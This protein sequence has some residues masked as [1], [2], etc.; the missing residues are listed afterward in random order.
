M[1]GFHVFSAGDEWYG[2]SLDD[3]KV[4][5]LSEEEAEK[6]GKGII[7]PRNEKCEEQ[8]LE[9]LILIAATDCNMRCRYC[10]ADHGSYGYPPQLMPISTAERAVEVMERLTTTMNSVS[11]FGGE[12][13]LN[14][15]LIEKIVPYIRTRHEDA[16]IRINTNGTL[17]SEKVIDMIKRY[18]M[19]VV[20]SLDGPK[21]I[22]DQLRFFA[23][24]RGSY[25][26]VIKNIEKLKRE[27]IP[28]EIEATYTK[29][30]F[31]AGISAREVAEH[32]SIY[33]D[34]L[35]IVPV[36]T[37]DTGLKLSSEEKVELYRE[38]LDFL[39]EERQKNKK[40]FINLTPSGIGGRMCDYICKDA[41]GKRLTVYPTGDSYPCFHAKKEIFFLGNI[42]DVNYEEKYPA[43]M[44]RAKK[45][46][47]KERLPSYWFVPI[48]QTCLANIAD[49]EKEPHLSKEDIELIT[50]QYEYFIERMAN[51]QLE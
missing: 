11:F 8:T 44:E 7:E 31:K 25:D 45:Y 46:M 6:Y 13:L 27:G 19:N 20:L 42:R 40:L 43:N 51:V 29:E 24:K 49:I 15:P 34:V 10:Y 14:L 28:F 4:F 5:I 36:V 2:I 17:I 41:A 21:A 35:H 18:R 38:L 16:V 3:G 1:A 39:I 23:N 22:N 26:T 30:H 50:Y 33:S 9:D 12:P 47:R 48:F 32:L 37:I